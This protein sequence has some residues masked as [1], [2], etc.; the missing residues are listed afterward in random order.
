MLLIQN[1]HHNKTTNN[2]K[3]NIKIMQIIIIYI[4]QWTGLQY[5]PSPFKWLTKAHLAVVL[6]LISA[7]VC[8]APHVLITH[9]TGTVYI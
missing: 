4:Y 7:C 9:P 1:Q 6:G 5:W 3:Q 2:Y 8:P